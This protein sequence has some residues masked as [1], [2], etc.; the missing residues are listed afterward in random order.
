MQKHVIVIGAG[1]VG[2]STAIWLRRFGQD[3]TIVD[4]DRPGQAASYGNAGLLAASAMVPVTTPGL[5]TKAPKMVLDPDSPLFVRWSYLP[6]IA[7]WLVR[8]LKH[9]NDRDTKRIAA[10]LTEITADTVAQHFALTD[11]LK[12]REFLTK[13]DYVYAYGSRV[14]FEDD[15]YAW[16]LKRQYGFPPTLIEG[17]DVQDYDPCFGSAIRCLAVVKDHGF[18]I[19]PGGYVAALASDFEAM[20]GRIVQASVE[21][22]ETSDP[23]RPRVVTTQGPFDCDAAVVASG[24]WSKQLMTRLGLS[25]PLESERGYHIVM[26]N[27]SGGPRTPSMITSGKFVATPMKAGLRCAGIVELGGLEAGPSEAP[28]ALL[29]RKIKSAFPDLEFDG[30]ETW[31]GHR[32]ATTDSL[33]LIGEVRNTGVYTAFGHQHVGL[34]AGPKTGRLVA[35]LISDQPSNQDLAPFSPHRFGL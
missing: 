11:G 22:I 21:D 19:D 1:I 24:A 23:S 29:R 34:T 18:V 2:V 9:A 13:S 33:P 12:A 8:Y 7:P 25:I 10:S 16:D 28:F 20:G 31:M 35:G 17:P 26:K 30:E 14:E 4:R 6:R 27:A 3:V 32:P 15:R 5:I